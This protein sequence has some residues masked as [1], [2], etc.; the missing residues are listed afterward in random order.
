[1][2]FEVGGRHFGSPVP[3]RW[4]VLP[5]RRWTTTTLPAGT[6]NVTAVFTPSD[7]AYGPSTSAVV[8]IVVSAPAA[9]SLS[10]SSCSDTQNIQVTVNPGTITITTPYTSANPF[11]LPALTLSTDGTYLQS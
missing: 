4:P 6:D 1:M 3:T 2:Q 11:V 9:C 7:S 10:G 8:A 5:V